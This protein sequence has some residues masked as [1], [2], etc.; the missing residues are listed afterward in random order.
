MS[1]L[2]KGMELPTNCWACP[3]ANKQYGY[4][5]IV[6]EPIWGSR[7]MACPLV[8]VPPHGRLID[9]DALID[10][11][12]IIHK[13]MVFGGQVVYSQGEIDNAPTIIEAEEGE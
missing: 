7:L 2:I 4:C 9:A 10:R 11:E 5:E 13:G 8:P 1:V 12:D 6:H 3:C